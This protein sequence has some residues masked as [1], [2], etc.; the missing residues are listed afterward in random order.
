MY[1]FCL[2]INKAVYHM[3]EEDCDSGY[4]DRIEFINKHHLKLVERM[5]RLDS[6]WKKGRTHLYSNRL[7]NYF[8]P[9]AHLKL[10]TDIFRPEMP[11]SV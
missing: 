5:Q 10:G 3:Q 7:L 1:L 2:F 11:S 8:L 6:R 4:W 9:Q